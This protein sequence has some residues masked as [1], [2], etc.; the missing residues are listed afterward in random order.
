MPG[1]CFS[2]P[3]AEEPNGRGRMRF[4][5]IVEQFVP[6]KGR[7]DERTVPVVSS[8]RHSPLSARQAKRHEEKEEEAHFCENLGHGM[9]FSCRQ[10][11]PR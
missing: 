5:P 8:G 10:S 1:A 6:P 2:S 11:L 4:A 9:P 3:H 7:R